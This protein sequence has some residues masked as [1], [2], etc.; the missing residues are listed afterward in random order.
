MITAACSIPSSGRQR[1]LNFTQ[2]DAIPADL[3]LLVG[4]AQILQLP[5]GAPAHQVAGAIHTRP[6]HAERAWDKPR[7]GQTRPA[8]IPVPDS[9][10]G[11]IQLPDHPGG[12]R[13]QPLVEHKQRRTREPASR[14]A[15]H[16]TPHVSGALIAA[17]IVVSVGP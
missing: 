7:R 12:H 15:P 5:I 14:S 3:D 10:A 11:H 16:P 9:G 8:H 13:A 6:G 1:G 17:Y 4:A 2:L